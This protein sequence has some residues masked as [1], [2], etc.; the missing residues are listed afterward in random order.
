VGCRDEGS[1][2]SITAAQWDAGSLDAI[3][4]KTVRTKGNRRDPSITG[5]FGA[6]LNL[7]G[8]D[9]RGMSLNRLQVT[10]RIVRD[11]DLQDVGSIKAAGPL[12]AHYKGDDPV[13]LLALD[14]GG[15]MYAVNFASLRKWPKTVCDFRADVGGAPVMAPDVHA[16]MTLAGLKGHFSR[17]GLGKWTVNPDKLKPGLL[18]SFG[19]TKDPTY[20]FVRNVAF[21]YDNALAIEALL[22]GDSFDAEAIARAFQIADALVLLQD[23]DPMNKDAEPDRDFPDLV[24]APVRD[25]YRNGNVAASRT[26]TKVKV[27]PTHEQ[28]SS[29]NQAY[30]AMA[31]LRAADVAENVGETDRAETYARTARELLLYVGRQRARSG[32]LEGFEMSDDPNV[33]R[34]RST[35]HNVDLG[36]AFEQA[37]HAETDPNLKALWQQWSTAADTFRDQMCGGNARF[38]TLPWISDDWEY[39]RAGTGLGDDINMDLVPIDAGAWSALGRNDNRGAAF[40]LLAFL[41]TST[42]VNG[43]TYTGFDPG[44]RAVADDNLTSRRDGVGTEVTAYMALIARKLGDGGVLAALPARTSLTPDEQAAHDVV[45]TA[46]NGG[47]SD[48]DLAS[49]IAG[50]LC[51]IQLCAPNGDGLGMVAAPV[52]NVGTGEYSLVSGWS[53]AA[54]CWSQ[55]AF[56]GWNPLTDSPVA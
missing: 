6:K 7:T 40:D 43:M 56:A 34:V 22:M 54:T 32:P 3:W 36:V 8:Q 51:R 45:V 48:H 29:G 16:A 27:K 52:P 24:P 31:L 41:A 1:V 5:D 37:A 9:A 46:A 15:G 30:V 21:V 50:E 11:L 53:L 10:G 14:D 35:E 42:D 49:F 17:S 26:S 38:G 18:A 19:K 12:V 20:R 13:G 39:H 55:W 2:G 23:H 25:G 33:G 47:S 44:F 4:A 28:A